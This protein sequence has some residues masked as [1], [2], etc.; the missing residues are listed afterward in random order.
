[1]NRAKCRMREMVVSI[2]LA[3]FLGFAFGACG[4]T[5][6]TGAPADTGPAPIADLSV[7]PLPS[8]DLLDVSTALKGLFGQAS[9]L[10]AANTDP[11]VASCHDDEGVSVCE[12]VRNGTLGGT[13]KQV[14]RWKLT[15]IGSNFSSAVD[16]VTFAFENYGL[17]NACT[18]TTVANGVLIC[19]FN[20]KAELADGGGNSLKIKGDCGG[21]SGTDHGIILASANGTRQIGYELILARGEERAT[22]ST[23]QIFLGSM[24]ISG[25]LEI[26]G[27]GYSYDFLN[28]LKAPPCP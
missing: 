9:I 25:I 4:S 20:I 17:G 18:P 2:V 10:G 23:E 14:S 5:A 19:A 11:A 7:S 16:D 13:L 6:P 24:L 28:E 26:D 22:T 12:V 1:M 27:A 21:S 8:G 3:S 15:E